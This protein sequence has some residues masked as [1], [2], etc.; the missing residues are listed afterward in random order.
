MYSSIIPILVWLIILAVVAFA[1]IKGGR[2]ER[3]G[4]VSVLAAGV[5]AIAIHGLAQ[6]EWQPMLLLAD[7]ALLA[8]AFLLLALRYTSVWLGGAMILQA[9]QFSLHAYYLVAERP[10]DRF[11]STVNNIDTLGVL[12]CILV[13]TLLTWRKRSRAAK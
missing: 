7:E 4:G 9:V 12:V 6:A 10:H 1:W 8:V 3:L 11:Y 13:G 2:P 5:A